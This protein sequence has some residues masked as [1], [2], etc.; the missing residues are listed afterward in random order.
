MVLKLNFVK[1]LYQLLLI[2]AV[3]HI[4]TSTMLVKIFTKIF[5]K[6]LEKLHQNIYNDF[7]WFEDMWDILQNIC[8]YLNVTYRWS[9]MFV[10]ARCLSLYGVTLSAIYMFNVFNNFISHFWVIQIKSCISPCWIQFTLVIRMKHLMKA[11]RAW[12]LIKMYWKKKEPH[13]SQKRK[14]RWYLRNL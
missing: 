1:V 13:E 10:A 12:K 7:K 14:K 8:K 9:E 6:Y 5:N 2:L 3:I 11:K 4:T